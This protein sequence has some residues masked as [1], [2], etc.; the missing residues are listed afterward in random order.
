MTILDDLKR[1]ALL[2]VVA[3]QINSQ[4]LILG[5]FIFQNGDIPFQIKRKLFDNFKMVVMKILGVRTSIF[6][7]FLTISDQ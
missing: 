4:L 3:N 6:F 1:C 2:I 5:Y 7:M